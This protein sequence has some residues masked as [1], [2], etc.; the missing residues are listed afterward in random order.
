MKDKK[1]VLE[2]LLCCVL[3]VGLALPAGLAGTRPTGAQLAYA[4]SVDHSPVDGSGSASTIWLP[5][6]DPAIQA[7][8]DVA[9]EA[10]TAWHI[11]TIDT[12]GGEYASLAFDSSG[13]PAIAYYTGHLKYARFNGT[14]W[15]TETV[16]AGGK[17]CSLAFDALGRPAISYSSSG[18]L[19]Y[20]HHNG[21]SWDI[22]MVE[23]V[24]VSRGTS[25]AFDSFGNPVICYDDTW[26]GK[27]AYFEFFSWNVKRVFPIHVYHTSIAV[28]SLGNPAVSYHEMPNQGLFYA[29]YDRTGTLT[30]ITLPH[31]LHPYRTYFWRV[32]YQDS[33]GNWSRWSSETAFVT[34][35]QPPPPESSG[36]VPAQTALEHEG[37][38]NDQMDASSPFSVD[39][40]NPPDQPA[41]VSPAH[42]A[43]GVSRNSTLQSSPFSD[44]DGDSHFASQWQIRIDV[45]AIN[46][47]EITV[48][49]S[50]ETTHFWRVRYQDDRGDW[51]EWSSETSFTTQPL[52]APSSRSRNLVTDTR[53][54]SVSRTTPTLS[55]SSEPPN[56]PSNVLPV[57]GATG[58]SLATTLVASAFSHPSPGATHYDSHWQ[59]RRASGDYRHS[60]IDRYSVWDTTITPWRTERVE[61]Y[62]SL[63]PPANVGSYNSLA[64]DAS[65]N[66]AISYY[67]STHGSLKY[68]YFDGSSWNTVTIDNEEDVGKFTSLAFD[69]AGNPG[70]SYYNETSDSLRYA[71]FN[72]T[73]WDIKTVDT[74]GGEYT[75]LAF[76]PAGHPAISYYDS[77]NGELKYACLMA[78]EPEIAGMVWEVDCARPPLE[79]VTLTLYDGDGVEVDSTVSDGDGNYTLGVPELGEYTVV[80][81]KDGFRQETQAITVSE[82]TAYTLDLIG[83]HGLIPDDPDV[84]Y[85]LDC[86]IRWK[87]PEAPCELDV[88]RVLDVIIAWKY[89]ILED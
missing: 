72:G 27:I 49:L 80:A 5:N 38:I 22:Q 13:N 67:D 66:P 60:L 32:R 39:G 42:G 4:R 77:T 87:Y 26:Y 14:S 24:H 40:N 15:D 10:E 41:N 35:E 53:V 20:A 29:Y 12:A 11:E 44:P 89:P 55:A 45:G 59:L 43:T 75:S 8:V 18:E 83:D 51:S 58:V 88:F 48:V 78:V 2:A 16:D 19:R 79:G 62:Y 85:V 61:S 28:D 7:A 64:F 76:D 65:D 54:T 6:D 9:G 21:V 52:S 86:I 69:H 30:Q 81:S 74:A 34:E 33:K 1:V 84:F 23:R 36:I 68:A 63:D 31:G 3:V 50:P 71:H 17:Y 70:I 37:S 57:D 82:A 47:T 46:L 56:Q 73:T 25:L